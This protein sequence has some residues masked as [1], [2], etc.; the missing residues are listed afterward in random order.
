MALDLLRPCDCIIFPLLHFFRGHLVE[1]EEEDNDYS[2]PQSI[3]DVNKLNKILIQKYPET[4]PII[5]ILSSR[6]EQEL[7]VIGELFVKK[8]GRALSDVLGLRLKEKDIPFGEL[9]RALAM[10]SAAYDAVALFFAIEGTG[11]D[12][13]VII[14]ILVGR[15]NAEI[16]AIKV[17][18]ERL[19]F[20]SLV[21]ALE[22]ESTSVFR[23]QFYKLIIALISIPRSESTE[24]EEAIVF[25]DIERLYDAGEGRFG[26]DNAVFIEILSTRSLAHL[27]RIVDLYGVKTL[28]KRDFLT[29]VKSEFSGDFEKA[30]VKLLLSAQHLDMHIAELF[31]R[32]LH[33]W[34]RKD[35]LLIRLVVRYRDPKVMAPIKTAY[36]TRYHRD[37]IGQIRWK[38]GGDYERL[39]ITLIHQ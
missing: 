14:E 39:L 22:I 20:Q 17:E 8:T 2:I 19:F 21:S 27:R 38:T 23:T 31:H 29:V 7:K 33:A 24:V 11:A 36:H 26:A 34:G 16:E 32:A 12:E 18:Y 3:K 30:V 13:D 10:S 35:D 6:S 28:K 15:T 1:E 37:L 4:L 25:S 5:R 9:A